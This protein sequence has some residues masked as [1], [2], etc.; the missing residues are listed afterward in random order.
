MKSHLFIMLA[1]LF[2]FENSL[3]AMVRKFFRKD[4]E[5]SNFGVLAKASEADKEA[6]YEFLRGREPMAL[7]FDSF[8]KEEEIKKLS[9]C[10]VIHCEMLERHCGSLV[11]ADPC[12]HSLARCLSESH[13]VLFSTVRRMA[14]IQSAHG[15]HWG[16]NHDKF[17]LLIAKVIAHAVY[18]PLRKARELGQVVETDFKNTKTELKIVKEEKDKWRGFYESA[19]SGRTQL[20]S[21]F[22]NLKE[23]HSKKVAALSLAAR[24][25]S[26]LENKNKELALIIAQREETALEVAKG[27]IALE[28]RNEELQQERDRSRHEKAD[29]T[30]YFKEEVETIGAFATRLHEKAASIGALRK[31]ISPLRRELSPLRRKVL[32]QE[33]ELK[34]KDAEIAGLKQAVRLPKNKTQRRLQA[35]QRVQQK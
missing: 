2:S 20:G 31:E 25:I 17:N 19:S 6:H 33:N 32:A 16:P 18:K 35:L 8:N 24:K 10:I 7:V 27:V 11:D 4:D 1:L 14:V 9:E 5:I 26:D 3:H 23:D 21:E 15:T 12:Y 22:A 34:Q 28:E 29:L 30:K 13:G